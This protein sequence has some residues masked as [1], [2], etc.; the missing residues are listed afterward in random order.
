MVLAVGV[1]VA[2]T[3]VAMDALPT[4][5]VLLITVPALFIVAFLALVTAE[6]RKMLRAYFS[7]FVRVLPLDDERL[8]L[9]DER[10]QPCR[11]W[12]AA[13]GFEWQGGYEYQSPPN[14]PIFLF[15]WQCPG[16]GVSLRVVVAQQ[17]MATS[18]HSGYEREHVLSSS[19]SPHLVAGPSIPGQ[20]DQAFPAATIDELWERHR[21]ADQYL[22]RQYHWRPFEDPRPVEVRWPEMNRLLA[23]TWQ[24]YRFWPLRWIWWS[25]T[26]RRRANIPAEQQGLERREDLRREAGFVRV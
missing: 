18:F 2:L 14:A 9:Y 17:A 10:L 1:F 13:K 23:R 7:P 11:D 21:Q 3:Y 5:L 26:A 15:K 6:I 19:D 20:V 16:R 22:Q 24:S 12:A 4:W 8:A 25:L